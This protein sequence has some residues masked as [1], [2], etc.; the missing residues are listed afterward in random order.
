[1]RRSCEK[2]NRVFSLLQQGLLLPEGVTGCHLVLD[3][4]VV[5]D[6]HQYCLSL[7]SPKNF[8]DKSNDIWEIFEVAV[9]G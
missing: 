5:N 7:L 2:K 4:N 8:F 1:M 3:Y 9:L 6:M